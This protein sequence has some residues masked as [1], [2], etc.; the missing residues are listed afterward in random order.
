MKLYKVTYISFT[1]IPFANKNKNNNKYRHKNKQ[2]KTK[3]TPELYY[4]SQSHP[5]HR[6]TIALNA[7][8]SLLENLDLPR[9]IL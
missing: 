1:L 2:N 5:L 8:T 4:L 6:V 7:K 3:K 9:M